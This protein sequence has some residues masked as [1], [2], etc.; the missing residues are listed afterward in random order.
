[1]HTQ[2][3]H[4]WARGPAMRGVHVIVIF[5]V[6]FISVANALEDSSL[7]Q[8]PPALA[9]VGRAAAGT[10]WGQVRQRAMLAGVIIR[11][12]FNQNMIYYI[13]LEARGLSLPFA[14]SPLLLRCAGGASSRRAAPASAAG[15]AAAVAVSTATDVAISTDGAAKP[16]SDAASASHA[17]SA[18]HTT[19]STVTRA[20]GNCST[21]SGCPGSAAA[22]RV[23]CT[24]SAHPRPHTGVRWLGTCM[25]VA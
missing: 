3:Q 1:M 18:Q 14:R 2:R 22:Q 25:A 9:N 19:P 24:L 17:V 16:C 7:A 13:L 6:T 21:P 11:S 15:H 23:L 8:S 5:T 12:K 20:G 4:V 10:A